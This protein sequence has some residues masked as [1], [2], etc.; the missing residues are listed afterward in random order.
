[1]AHLSPRDELEGHVRTDLASQANALTR[2]Q[3]MVGCETVDHEH[4]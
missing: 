4:A 2:R 3:V 1:M